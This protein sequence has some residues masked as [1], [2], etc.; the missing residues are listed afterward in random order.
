MRHWGRIVVGGS[1]EAFIYAYK[2]DLPVLCVKPRPPLFLDL[3]G[4]NVDFGTIGIN[5]I[6]TLKTPQGLIEVGS[7]KLQIWQKLMFLLSMSGKLLYA[8]LI[9]S[10]KVEGK[11]LQIS[12]D[13]MKRQLVGFERLEVFDDHG[14]IGMPEIKRRV[15]RKNVVYDWVNIVSGGS[16]DYDLFQYSGNFVK[17]VHFYSSERSDNSRLKD[18]VAVSYL[19]DEELDDFSYSSTY[20]RFKLLEHFKELGIRG[21][22]NGRDVKRP[23]YYK[24]YAVKLEPSNR[25]VDERVNTWYERDSRFGIRRE[26]AEKLLKVDAEPSGYLQRLSRVM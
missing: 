10:V 26:S 16:H 1:L 4:A 18:L 19:T 22:R 20:V 24:Y 11:Q 7:P 25:Q 17:T 9:N 8:D 3:F 23:G 13:R 14:L 6:R 12:C 5:E 21:A 2:H 15:K